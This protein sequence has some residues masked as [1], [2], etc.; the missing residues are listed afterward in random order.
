MKVFIGSENP[1]KI[2]AVREL[3]NEYK[4]LMDAKLFSKR[5]NSEVSEQPKSLEETV[6]GAV[7]R[8]KTIFYECDYSFGIESGMMKVPQTRTGSM[9]FCACAIYDGESS[10]LGLSCAFEFPVAVTKMIHEEDIDASEAYYR[11]GLTNEKDIGSLQG[12]IGLLTRGRITRK[13]YTKQAVRMA[14]IQLE[15]RDLY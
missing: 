15:N 10:Y 12:A 2:A 5:I 4:F 3:L 13:D 1:V 8:A 7:N 9:D 6:Q 11:L 14:L